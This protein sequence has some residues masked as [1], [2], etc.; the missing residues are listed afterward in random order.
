MGP[1]HLPSDPYL[2]CQAL[3]TAE[4]SVP[5]TGDSIGARH[6]GLPNHRCQ[7]LGTQSLPH[8]CL[9]ADALFDFIDGIGKID[10]NDEIDCVDGGPC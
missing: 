1:L 3:G 7:A 6:W 8:A 2:R 4:S 9:T 10:K 5:G